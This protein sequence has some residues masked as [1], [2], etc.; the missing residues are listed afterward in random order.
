M[1]KLFPALLV[2]SGIILAGCGTERDTETAVPEITLSVT[3]KSFYGLQTGTEVS[4]VSETVSDGTTLFTETSAVTS[5]SAETS[6]S[7]NISETLIS[8]VKSENEPSV[9]EPLPETD[10]NP[11]TEAEIKVSETEN[12][13]EKTAEYERRRYDHDQGCRQES[14]C[15]GFHG[16]QG[17]QSLS[18]YFGGHHQTR[19]GGHR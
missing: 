6:V 5:G 2:L 16:L 8:E 1:K 7:E 19:H 9:T 14:R 3:G 18:Q 17:D 11:V 13:N 10:V 12:N 15:S 4:S